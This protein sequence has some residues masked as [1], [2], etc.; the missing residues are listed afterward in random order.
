MHNLIWETT[1]GKIPDGHEVYH[2]NGDVF[3]NRQENLALRKTDD[4]FPVEEFQIEISNAQI[5]NV[6]SIVLEGNDAYLIDDVPPPSKKAFSNIIKS[7]RSQ[8]WSI[9]EDNL[10]ILQEKMKNLLKMDI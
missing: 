5:Y 8:G 1:F 4:P 10:L 2:I 9:S 6:L 7:L 3:D